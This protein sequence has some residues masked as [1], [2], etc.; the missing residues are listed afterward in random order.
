MIKNEIEVAPAA[1]RTAFAE[2]LEHGSVLGAYATYQGVRYLFM[3]KHG[4]QVL[5][6]RVDAEEVAAV[7]GTC[8]GLS[9]DER[10]MADEFGVAFDA[11]PDARPFRP[12]NG[13]LASAVVATGPGVTQVVVGPVHAGI[14]EPG[15]FTFSSGGETIAHLDFQMGYSY[16]RL[17]QG[18]E[19]A[20]PLDLAPRV[21][22]VCGA[23]S[24]SRSLAYAMAVE[25]ISDTR[26][27][28]PVQ[29]ARQIIVE[30]ERV[31]NHLFDLAVCSAAAGWGFGQ[32]T[33]L[34][35]KE[36]ALRV[37]H[38]ATGHRMLFDA[39]VP[40]GV[41]NGVLEDREQVQSLVIMLQE[42]VEQYLGAIF[43]NSSL[44]SRWN[45]TGTLTYEAARALAVVGP[46]HRASGGSLDVRD[47]A[48]Y[49]AYR[50][51]PIAVARE[52][53][54]DVL[55]RCRV[56]I[57]ELRGSFG[58]IKRAF[59]HLGGSPLDRSP[60]MP[61][62]T[63]DTVTVVEGPRGAETVALTLRGSVV[64]RLHFISASYRNWPAVAHATM[65]NIVPDAP[66]VNKSFNLCYACADR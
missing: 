31:Y 32:A 57:A 29:I 44:L 28:D 66:L 55:A 61:P 54:G 43:D 20:D 49:G 19:G 41:S 30:L 60:V 26:V 6:A 33:G 5:S 42:A 2:R 56:K 35:L 13:E 53:G 18:V 45:E 25:S 58:I 15:R 12:A 63:G 8:P 17:E 16:R 9:W 34:G 59:E 14:I 52:E 47:A 37:C 27:S 39:I 64:E 46:A 23:C 36:R 4:V 7:S 40:G 21:A 3:E 62:E 51:M 24:A 22:R 10:E 11:L 38:A 48:P 1:M 65:G 50:W